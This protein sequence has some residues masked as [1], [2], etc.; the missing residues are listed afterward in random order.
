MSEKDKN[1][2]MRFFAAANSY[3]GFISYFDS[4]FSS[5]D[6]DR[7]YTLK[8]GPGTG[9]SSFM[10]RVSSIFFKAG[11]STE[12]IVCSSDP[13]SL[14]GVIISFGGK[15]IAII[16]GT[17]PHERDARIPGAIDEL[18]YLGEAWDNRWLSA[19]K[20]DIIEIGDEKSFSYK[21]AYDYLAQAGQSSKM[22][23]NV[24]KSSFDKFKAK[25][26]AEGIFNE[27]KTKNVGKASTRLISS[28]GRYGEHYLDTLKEQNINH[29][30][31]GG[32]RYSAGLFLSYISDLLKAE[33][34]C[35]THFPNALDPSLTDAIY[36][37]E[38]SIA[39]VYENNGSISLN[40]AFSPS[41]L[42]LEKIKKAEW[43]HEEALKE[44]QRWFGIASDLH[45]RLEKI[46]GEAMNFDIS[47][48]IITTKISEIA[49]ILEITI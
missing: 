13:K 45:F 7:I 24:Y 18:I 40:E 36:F 15:K 1:V 29:I 30:A 43:L 37:S 41:A 38:S 8:G 25:S 20:Q 35:F 27:I 39:I 12:E 11:C 5:R 42:E 9:K 47:D 44:A 23:K 21:T 3:G 49:N 26:L 2:Q 4:V 10:K 32:N 19:K 46:Y 17:A 48:Q 16:D 31:I 34:I 14:D 22:M 33:R 6:F 28:F